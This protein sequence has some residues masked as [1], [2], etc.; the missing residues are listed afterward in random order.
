MHIV[1]QIESVEMFSNAQRLTLTHLSLDKIPSA[2]HPAKIRVRV[3]DKDNDLKAGDVVSVQATLMP[4]T[5]PFYVGG[6]PYS[7]T[8][9]YNKTGATGYAVGKVQVINRAGH[10]SII[11]SVRRYL[12]NCIVSVMPPEQ[13]AIAVAL[14]TG[15]QGLISDKQ[16]ADYTTAGIAHILSV[17]GFHMGLIAGFVFLLFRLIFLLFPKFSHQHD[18][19]KFCAVMALIA[20][21]MYLLISG[22]A[23]PAQRAFGMVTSILIGIMCNRR[24]VSLHSVFWIGF[25]LLVIRPEILM[26]A[27][28]ALSFGAV[29]ALVACHEAFYDRLKAFFDLKPKWVR[30][31]FF[32]ILI[33]LMINLIAHLATAPI[34]MYHFHRYA[35]YSVL[36]NFIITSI[37]SFLIMPILF[38]ASLLSIF[39]LA[40]PLFWLAGLLLFLINQI[41]SWIATFP[42]ASVYVPSM[43][44]WGYACLIAGGLILCLVRGRVRL[45]GLGLMLVSFISFETLPDVLINQGGS[46]WAFRQGDAYV[47]SSKKTAKSAR[48]AWLEAMGYNP[49]D[50]VKVDVNPEQVVNGLRI[51]FDGQ[52]C[53]ACDVI[54]NTKYPCKDKLCIPRKKLWKEGTHALYI[55]NGHAEVKSV[56]DQIGHRPWSQGFYILKNHNPSALH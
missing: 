33:V 42:Y 46:I 45:C 35:N 51:R 44:D 9:F 10:E 5:L 29:T 15:D 8:A 13:A 24:A 14:V 3:N 54:I 53:D 40:Y 31:I 55:K 41:C 36:G 49:L 17:S 39:G 19:K 26:T 34:A 22:M 56:A 11:E 37:F 25:V 2:E 50:K 52:N 1:G 27:S 21:F 6:Y 4:P 43:A 30:R 28:F 47:F 38:C 7:R 12:R 48:R 20:T 16:R 32:P 23:V 18:T